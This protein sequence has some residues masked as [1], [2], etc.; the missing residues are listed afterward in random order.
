MKMKGSDLLVKLLQENDVSYIFGVPGGHLLTFYDSLTDTDEIIPILTK[1]ESGAS[2]MATGFAQVSNELGVCAGTVGPG[3]TNLI[4]GVA[5]AYMDS[6]PVLVLTA[7]VGSST[8]GKGGLQEAT[9]EGRT[10]NHVEMFDGITKYSTLVS[11]GSGIDRAFR[12]AVVEA[13]NGRPGPSH[14]DITA[15]TFAAEVEIDSSKVRKFER[16]PSGAL[17]EE[18]AD[19]AELL[20]S[21]ENPGILAGAGAVGASEAVREL[22]ESYKIPVA[23]TLKGKGII[24]ENHELSVGCVGLY[25]TNVANKVFRDGIDVLLA[26]GVSFS[27]FT[28]HAWDPDFRPET[29]LIQVDIDPWEMGKNY[30]VA[31]ELLGD[32]E[33]VLDQVLQELGQRGRKN[34]GNPEKIATE[35]AKR[36]YYSD[37]KM[38]S[39]D[40]PIKPQRLMKSLRDALPEDTI[41]FSDIGNNLTW[42]ESFFQVTTPNSYFLSPSLASMGYAV[43]ASIGGQLAAPDRQVVCVCG[44]GGFQMQGMEIVT[45]VNYDIPVKW[46]IMNNS[47]LGMIRDTQDQLFGGKRIASDF[48][49]PDFVQLAEAM[50]AVGLR[51]ERP[52]EI[53]EVTEAALNNSRPTVVDVRIDPDEAPSFDARAEAMIRAWGV[54]PSVYQKLKMIPEVMKRR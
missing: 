45:A 31:V 51:I 17:A 6:T 49:N 53:A 7:Q 28:T 29:G 44:D 4:T 36:D 32:A 23:T 43:A 46:F 37:P 26:V 54:K 27:E 25:G 1:H 20:L 47:T 8:V 19:A 22:A 10:P 13:K 14:L 34:L 21:S 38:A 11:R 5:S 18:I 3:A 35:K 33:I 39:T 52:E 12:N 9:G 48:L 50:G 24:P 40:V 42:M 2:F 16:I 15:D 30:D 41:L